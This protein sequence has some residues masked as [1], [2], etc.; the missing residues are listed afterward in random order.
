MYYPTTF[1][2]IIKT[3]IYTHGADVDGVSCAILAIIAFPNVDY[4]LFANPEELNKKLEEDLNT[5]KLD[6]YNSVFITD[7]PVFKEN[8]GRINNTKELRRKVVIIDHHIRTI[9]EGA[10]NYDFCFVQ[11]KLD[12]R[13]TC[14][15][16]LFYRWLYMKSFVFDLSEMFDYVEHVRQNDT[17]DWRDKGDFGDFSHKLSYLLNEIGENEYINNFYKKLLYEPILKFSKSDEEVIK[18]HE[19]KAKEELKKATNNIEYFVD[20]DNNK[21]AVLFAPYFLRNEIPDYIRKTHRPYE[22]SY[23]IIVSL[24]VCKYGQKS[25]RRVDGVCDLNR[26]TAKMNGGGHK[27]SARVMISKTQREKM[28]SFDDQKEALQYIVNQKYDENN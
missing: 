10:P 13:F 28:D 2:T 17:W 24:D 5:H 16:E 1:D 8:L 3:K 14:A 18:R 22:I 19:E 21:V 27:N 26:I 23:V 12:E 9:D 4:E 25:F 11:E 20:K 15:T 7:L 6:N